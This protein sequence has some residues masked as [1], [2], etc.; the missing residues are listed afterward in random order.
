MNTKEKY[1]AYVN[2]AFMAAVEP[3]VIDRAEGATYWDDEGNTYIDCF[4]G[5]SVVNS[6]HS[7]KVVIDAA[8]AQM[9]KLVHCPSCFYHV[10]A[11]ADLAEK[12]AEITPGTLK[13]TFFG[14]GGAEAVE[15]A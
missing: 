4:S 1:S 6:G 3:V 9:E 7:N 12:L 2:T 5:I 8:R 11:V 15:G 10:E 14:N 13:K